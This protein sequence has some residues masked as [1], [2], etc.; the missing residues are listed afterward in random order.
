M[1][2]RNAACYRAHVRRDCA[3]HETRNVR[4]D[5]TLERL[6]AMPSQNRPLSAAAQRAADRKA[7]TDAV[8]RAQAESRAANEKAALDAK[9]AED[10][11]IAEKAAQSATAALATKAASKRSSEK[12]AAAFSLNPYVVT[13]SDDA[14]TITVTLPQPLVLYMHVMSDGRH[15]VNLTGDVETEK[16]LTASGVTRERVVGSIL[17][18]DSQAD[19]IVAAKYGQRNAAYRAFT[20]YLRPRAIKEIATVKQKNVKLE[21]VN[22]INDAKMSVMS[23]LIK[24]TEP[25]AET[26]RVAL[27]DGTFRDMYAATRVAVG[28]PVDETVSSDTK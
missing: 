7:A 17:D 13:D 6:M 22:A 24:Q 16:I 4:R 12:K 14:R 2:R 3:T 5:A 21:A 19:R 25:N 15:D 9:A 28:M 23:A 27:Q 11:K 26:L 20:A 18:D 10:A 8:T 1:K